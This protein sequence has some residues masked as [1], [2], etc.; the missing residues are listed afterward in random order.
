MRESFPRVVT[1]RNMYDSAT[2]KEVLQW[3][4]VAQD[5]VVAENL[6]ILETME[7]Y[8]E[9][10]EDGTYCRYYCV[11]HASHVMFWLGPVDTDDIGIRPAVA[12]DHLR[13]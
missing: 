5:Y 10:S 8:L 9:P 11:D 4:Q 2:Q 6:N 1:D 3:V 7:I 12:G 13:A